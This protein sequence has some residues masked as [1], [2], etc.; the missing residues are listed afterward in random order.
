MRP[1]EVNHQQHRRQYSYQYLTSEAPTEQNKEMHWQIKFLHFEQGLRNP[2]DHSNPGKVEFLRYPLAAF[3]RSR[4][5]LDN[6]HQKTNSKV[7]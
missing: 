4:F 5:A 2:T 7:S 6:L 3:G 1:L